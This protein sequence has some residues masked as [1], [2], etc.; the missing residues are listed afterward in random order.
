VQTEQLQMFAPSIGLGGTYE[1]PAI[2]RDIV[3]I[4]RE[5]KQTS[6]DAAL[7]AKPKTGKKRQRVHAYLLGRPA[8]DEEIE[9]ALNMS[10]NT[11]RPTRGTL[12]KDGHV[13]DSG[14][15]R[16]TRA[17]NQAIVWRCV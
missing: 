13:I 4:A 5:A 15:R 16:L 8:T 7:K 2:N 1:R 11:V 17:G 9:T 14:I 6:V 10:G 3:I 12:V